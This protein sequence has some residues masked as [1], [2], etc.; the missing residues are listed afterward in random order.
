[1]SIKIILCVF[2]S[3]AFVGMRGEVNAQA[4]HPQVSNAETLKF[5]KQFEQ[6]DESQIQA[7]KTFTDAQTGRINQIPG[8]L[9]TWVQAANKKE[10]CKVYAA[11]FVESG[12]SPWWE[13]AGNYV[14]WDG[15]CVNGY[16][17]GIGRE[18]TLEEGELSAW[19]A[20]Y[21]AEKKPPK[22]YFVTNYNRQTIEFKAV[23]HPLYASLQYV[24][25]EGNAGKQL[26]VNYS[27]LNMAE[28]RL[29]R[30]DGVVGVDQVSKSLLLPN[31]NSYAVVQSTNPMAAFSYHTSVTDK[32]DRVGY[33]I[34][35]HNNGIERKIVQMFNPT[36]TQN[37]EV[38]LP[39]S[40]IGH[41]KNVDA[42]INSNLTAGER[43]L[44][45][46]FAAIR[47]Y[48]ARVCQGTV[49]VEFMDS[50]VYGRVCLANGELSVFNDLIST[51][52]EQQKQ[53]HD[54]AR[55]EIA[56]RKQA[57]PNSQPAQIA[58]KS[59]STKKIATSLQQFADEVEKSSQR[60]SDFAH[61][62][63]NA[64]PLMIIEQSGNTHSKVNCVLTANIV[65]CSKR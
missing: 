36:P 60:T 6:V 18:F 47:Q 43:T 63:M 33:S 28:N 52:L 2:V 22:Y 15:S 14:N 59:V 27:V 53:A 55:I 35:N 51:A 4:L 48:Q 10:T 44:Q 20:D 62:T 42:K 54:Q 64:Q 16:A 46:A 50:A 39:A 37:V 13:K 26:A 40:Y 32:W 31:R 38:T 41:L 61:L 17:S 1:M 24:L 30:R 25:N 65:Q 21:H 8:A 57:M 56:R 9:E 34:V 7:W 58:A 45:Q 23:A 12:K 29:Y 19:L 49:K 3:L 11:T 5:L